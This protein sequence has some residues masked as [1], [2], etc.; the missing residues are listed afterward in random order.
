MGGIAAIGNIARA[1][2]SDQPGSR[3]AGRVLLIAFCIPFLAFAVLVI[4][5]LVD[6]L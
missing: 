5:T 2:K 4:F 3:R 6:R 1:T